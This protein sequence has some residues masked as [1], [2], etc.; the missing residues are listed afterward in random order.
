MTAGKSNSKFTLSSASGSDPG[1]IRK[2]NEDSVFDFVRPGDQG[3][4]TGLFIVADG[5]GGHQAGD[6]ASRL[7]VDTIS[8]MMRRHLERDDAGDTV[9]VGTGKKKSGNGKSRFYEFQVRT[10]INQANT[11]IHNYAIKHPQEAGNL[12]TTV[13]CAYVKGQQAVI[14]HVGDSRVY[15]FRDTSLEKLTEDHSLVSHLIQNGQIRP[16]DVYDHP[17]RSIIT[18]ALGYQK[19]VSIDVFTIP[20]I[21]GDQLMLC[22]DGLWEMIRDEQVIVDILATEDSLEESVGDLILTA[23]R[24]GGLDNIGVSLC[25]LIPTD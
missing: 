13:A 23:K 11:T 6:I 9:P 2:S 14:G 8:E 18:R 24:N 17:H 3:E 12:G 15:L 20:L 7:A 16:E 21:P 22:S 19:E 1:L 4:P 25:K 10:A 5:M